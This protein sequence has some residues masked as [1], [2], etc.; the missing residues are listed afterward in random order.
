MA[1]L[2]ETI[3]LTK[4]YH[5]SRIW[6]LSGL[7]NVK[8]VEKV[9]LKVKEGEVY[10]LVGE[11]GCGKTTMGRLVLRLVEPT[12]GKVLFD[13]KDVLTFNA[14][15]MKEYR[16]NTQI[17]FQ[18]PFLSMNPRR[19][20]YDSLSAGFDNHNIGTKQERREWLEKLMVRVGL[21]P[22]YLSRYPHQFSGGQLQRIVVAHRA[23]FKTQ[24]R[25]RR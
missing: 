2:V 21:D 18:N 19:S 9:S 6:I 11:S 5:P 23:I 24:V 16:R 8:A 12:M 20:I 13:G 3:D 14:E 7:K 22:A 4:Y 1:T 25:G 17:V 10:G 15:Q